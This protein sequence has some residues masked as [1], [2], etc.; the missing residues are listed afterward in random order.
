MF[1]SALR[2]CTELPVHTFTAAVLIVAVMLPTAT[3]ASSDA[4]LQELRQQMEEINRRIEELERREESTRTEPPADAELQETVEDTQ[5]RVDELETVVDRID[6]QVGSRAVVSAFDALQLDFGGFVDL[7][8]THVRG[9]DD[10]ATSFN[11]SVAELLIRAQLLDDWDLFLAQAFVRKSDPDFSDPARP[12]FAD[13]DSVVSDTVLAWA[14]YRHSDVL[15][16][17]AGRFI[18]PHGI[19]NIDHFPALLLD[20]DQPQFLRPFARQT[21]FPNFTNGF[22][23]HGAQFLGGGIGADQVSYNLYAGNFAGN[24]TEFNVGGRLEYQLGGT[25]L[26]IGLN[27]T[28]GE[29]EREVESRY[30]VYGADLEFDQGPIIWQ[31]EI[32]VTNEDRGESRFAAYSQP[33]W[34]LSDR[35]T[36]FYR[37]D[38][39]ERGSDPVTLQ[40]LQQ[41]TEHSLGLS[42]RPNRNV[43]LRAIGRHTAFDRDADAQTAQLSATFSF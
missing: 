6:D 37:F 22:Q 13:L 27:A 25:G 23:I 42:F 32:F 4:E 34:R 17:Q 16:F 19:V 40:D 36:A 1:R 29:R 20:P 21:I 5:W 7:A 43:H 24:A 2:T 38:Y 18:T 3:Q 10:S 8:A 41:S 39:L 15:Q 28:Y 14:N 35:W 12:T 30:I 11:R 26:A 31:N 9:D 33:G